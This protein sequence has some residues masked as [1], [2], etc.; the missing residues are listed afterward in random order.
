MYFS[1]PDNLQIVEKL[2]TVKKWKIVSIQSEEFPIYFWRNWTILINIYSE[3]RE[4]RPYHSSKNLI[5]S[6]KGRPASVVVQIV[7]IS[8][9]VNTNQGRTSNN[10]ATWI[11]VE[12]VRK[13]WAVKDTSSN[14]MVNAKNGSIESALSIYR[15][16]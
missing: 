13:N 8:Q 3:N 14:V 4:I 11:I 9:Q 6:K 5:W 1:R 10:F 15:G 16:M 2:T 7:F 12:N